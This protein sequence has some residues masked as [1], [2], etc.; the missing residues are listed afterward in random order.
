M[1]S[2]KTMNDIK[3]ISNYYGYLQY[4]QTIEEC[5][6]L[7]LAI[8][9]YQRMIESGNINDDNLK[10]LKNN[11]IEEIADVYC[12]IEQLKNIVPIKDEQIEKEVK[13]KVERQLK[14][15]DREKNR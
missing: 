12:M 5:S 6:E 4:G 1:I 10:E 15:I 11:I 2:D 14:R 13:L 7:I 3:F 8:R 9:K